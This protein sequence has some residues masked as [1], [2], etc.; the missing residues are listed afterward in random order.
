[1]DTE[2]TGFGSVTLFLVGLAWFD[3]NALA[4]EQVYAPNHSREPALLDRLFRHWHRASRLVT[5]NGRSY[6][7]PLIRDRIIRHRLPPLPG[8]EDVDL[9]T[10][11]RRRWR[12]ELPNCRLTTLESHVLGRTRRGDVKGSEIP[13]LYRE[14][15]RT[16]DPRVMA[17]VI[18]HNALDL[19]TTMELLP[20]LDPLADDAGRR[21][22]GSCEESSAPGDGGRPT[23]DE[24]GPR[25]QRSE[26]DAD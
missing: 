4:F 20:E 24:T 8:V 15:V 16:G 9:L 21:D 3:G 11:A 10:Y 7:L 1:M 13:R 12:N 25:W 6:D 14:S 26:R 17:R 22:G 2:T 18:Y 19:V 23:G 5:F